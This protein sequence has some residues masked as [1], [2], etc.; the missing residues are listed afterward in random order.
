MLGRH[1][2][3][4]KNGAG[5]YIA[6]HVAL[7]HQLTLYRT[8]MGLLLLDAE[9][10]RLFHDKPILR[11][12]LKQLPVASSNEAFAAADAI[13]WRNKMLTETAQPLDVPDPWSCAAAQDDPFPKVR[14]SFGLYVLLERIGAAVSDNA[15]VDGPET[16]A[17]HGNLLVSWHQKYRHTSAFTSQ[18]R[19]LMI[20]WHSIFMLLDVDMDMLEIAAGRDGTQAM[21]SQKSM[22]EAWARSPQ[23]S[24]CMAHAMLL[25]QQFER[26][27]LGTEPPLHA[28]SCL[29][30]CGIA[31]Y[32]YAKYGGGRELGH[33]D[34]PEL[35]YLGVNGDSVL[36][37]QVSLL[38]D[39]PLEAT[40]LLIVDLLKRISHWKVAD[41]FAGTLLALVDDGQ[42]LY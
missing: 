37:D 13:S 42:G 33:A 6:R 4:M 11:N 34:M 30:R 16:R 41:R 9:I 1:G 7:T 18:E 35:E 22:V 8:A 10:G 27:S 31:W 15:D 21:N 2:H 38:L 17:Q 29:Y 32:C 36:S 39:K 28:A 23:A 5:I 12:Q 26:I 14:C 19:H 20:L 40:L 24:R 25:Q 3:A